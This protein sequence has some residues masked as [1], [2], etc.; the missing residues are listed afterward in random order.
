[1]LRLRKHPI[2][3]ARDLYFTAAL[4]EV[5][6][7]AASKSKSPFLDIFRVPRN[8][9]AFYASTIVMF[10]QQVRPSRSRFVG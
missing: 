4:M 3:A 9:R 8:R 6:A 5:E 10:G 1:M 7:E 2:I